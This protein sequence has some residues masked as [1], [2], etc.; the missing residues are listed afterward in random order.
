VKEETWPSLLDSY[1]RCVRIVRDQPLYEL[2]PDVLELEEELQ[3]LAAYEQAVISL[4]GSVAS[5]VSA[6]ADMEPAISQF[7]DNVLVMDDDVQVRQN[8][9]ALL[10]KITGLAQGIADLSYLEGF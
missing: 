3:L 1:S 9:L 2:R 8:R 6:L 7:F 4:D 10:Q 5:F